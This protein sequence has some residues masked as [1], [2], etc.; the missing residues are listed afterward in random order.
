MAN[1]NH[2]VETIE[3]DFWREFC[4]REGKLRTYD[5]G[6]FFLRAGQKPKYLGYIESGYFKYSVVDSCGEEHITGFALCH[7]LAGDFYSTVNNAAA[8]N[9]LTAAVNSAVWVVDTQKVRLWLDLHPEHRQQLAEELFRMAHERYLNMYRQSPKERYVALIK[10]CPDIFPQ[11]SLK[12]LASYLQITPTH[13]SR[14]R[15]E[16]LFGK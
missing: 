10:R 15:K 14:I 8:L 2:Y 1:F 13:L 5:K 6:D 4:Q 9:H 12:E 3:L 7:N 11:V 16:I